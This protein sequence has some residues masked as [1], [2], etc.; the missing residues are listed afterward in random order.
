MVHAVGVSVLFCIL[1]KRQP[2]ENLKRDLGWADDWKMVAV[3]M[4]ERVG[5]WMFGKMR[6]IDKPEYAVTYCTSCVS[7]LILQLARPLLGR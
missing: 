4:L 1:S 2:E 7:S 3:P 6:V 5:R